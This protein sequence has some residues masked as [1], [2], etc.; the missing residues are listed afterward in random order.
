MAEKGQCGGQGQWVFLLGYFLSAYPLRFHDICGR[1]YWHIL[2]GKKRHPEKETVLSSPRA[3]ELVPGVLVLQGRQGSRQFFCS[4]R[5]WSESSVLVAN[6][7]VFSIGQ[8]TA[9]TSLWP[10]LQTLGLSASQVTLCFV[11]LDKWPSFRAPGFPCV[12]WEW[13]SE[14]SW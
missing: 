11:S 3:N 7:I 6:L 13:V 8:E 14:C 4:H 12:R 9:G 5:K 1:W 10:R 2:Q